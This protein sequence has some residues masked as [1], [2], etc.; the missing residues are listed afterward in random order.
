[1]ELPVNTKGLTT[2]EDMRNCI[3]QGCRVLAAGRVAPEG[4]HL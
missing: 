1:M 3:L 4:T 2:D